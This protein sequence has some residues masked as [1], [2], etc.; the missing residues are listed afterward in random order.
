VFTLVLG[1]AV[2]AGWFLH[3]PALIQILPQLPPMTR[4]A[5]A[6]FALCGLALLSI[7]GGGPR[8]L[9]VASTGTVA[10]VIQSEASA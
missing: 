7:V 10:V 3:I 9:V 8:W 1:V 5:A 4:I 2:L 6:S